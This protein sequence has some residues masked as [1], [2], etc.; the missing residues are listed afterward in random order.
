MKGLIRIVLGLGIALGALGAHA[1]ARIFNQAEL[2]ALLA[3]IALYPDPL[4]N[5]VVDASLYP[6]EVAQAAAWSRANPQLQGDAALRTVEHTPWHPSVKALVAYPEVLAR[7]GESPQ[8]VAD[9]GEAYA[10]HGPYIQ[11]TVQQLRA[12]AQASGYLQSDPYQQVYTEGSEIVV[13]PAVPNVAYVPYYN[14]YV[15][16]GTWWW[17]AYRPVYWRPWVPRPVYVTRVFRPV[18]S[19]P[20]VRPVHVMPAPHFAPVPRFARRVEVTPYHAVPESR[21][22]PIIQSA[23]ALTRPLSIS[24]PVNAGQF[25]AGA[26][27]QAHVSTQASAPVSRFSASRASAGQRR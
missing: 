20:I 26:G 22:Q 14:P 6:D 8:W 15:V 16:Y 19:R 25:R 23:P 17:P 1:Q 21:R 9:L 12:R 5:D 10:T 2:D 3:P 7:M 18:V 27:A 11:T 4:L 24:R 13:Q